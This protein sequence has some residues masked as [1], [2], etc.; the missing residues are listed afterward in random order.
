MPLTAS[1]RVQ[2][3]KEIGSRLGAEEWD[4]IDVTLSQF[5]CPTQNQW[6]GAKSTY[7][8]EMAKHAD[9]ST[10][11][12]L[13][14]HVGYIEEE[15]PKP[16]IDPPFWRPRMFRVF[17]SHLSTERAYAAQLQEA[18]LPFGIT[19]FVAH[20]DIEPTLEW[21]S[22]IEAAL[23]TAD[24]LIALLHPQFH[25]SKW[26]DQEIGFA[27]G[28]GLP[29]FAV[30]FGQDPYGFVAR[31]QA[32]TG[33][34][35]TVTALAQELFD[36]YRKNKQTQKRIA[37]V[38]VTLFETS[39]TFA[40]AKTR[41]GYL[42]DLTTWDTSFISRIKSALESNSQISDSWGVPE[43]VAALATKWAG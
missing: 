28:R 2:F 38:L 27:M 1:K 42:E 39:P 18:L 19:A 14:Q 8:M 29:V 12:E 11:T 37:E 21:Q 7:V 32:F 17:I 25:E 43:R 36:A 16:G 40:S 13:S 33:N 31:F 5:G 10:L 4:L 15:A 24:S 26:T 6:S 20:N 30:R 3:L 22:Q 35:K 9:D 23:T 34:G 41:V